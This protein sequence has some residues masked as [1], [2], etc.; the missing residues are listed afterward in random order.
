[1]I[2]E[3]N[4]SLFSREQSCKFSIQGE[5]SVFCHFVLTGA[6][7]I[8]E[9]INFCRE[10]KKTTK[11]PLSRNIHIVLLLFKKSEHHVSN[12]LNYEKS[13]TGSFFRKAGFLQLLK[14]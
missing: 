2:I 14:N 13:P 9:I 10:K 3:S 6:E 4:L 11:Q 8:V 7:K 12:V 1:M 5:I